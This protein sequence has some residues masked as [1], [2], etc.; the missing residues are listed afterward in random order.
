[1]STGD[2]DYLTAPG[3][4]FSWEVTPPRRGPRALLRHVLRHNRLTGRRGFACPYCKPPSLKYL[5][6]DLTG[7]RD[8]LQGPP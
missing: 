2:D 1:M 5:L 7:P 3:T 4:Q 8:Y 6:E